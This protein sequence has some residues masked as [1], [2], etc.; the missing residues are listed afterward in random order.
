M[1]V[2]L[3]ALAVAFAVSAACAFVP[4]RDAGACSCLGPRPALLTPDRVDDAPLNTRVR[5]ELPTGT[6]SSV[7]LREHGGP[8]VP[9]TRRGSPSGMLTMVELSPVSPLL[10]SKQYEVALIDP[11]RHPAT[12][13][14][15][16]FRTGTAIDATHPRLDAMGAPAVYRNP[17][18]MGA[19]CQVGGPWI[20]IDGIVAVDPERP[21]AQLLVAVW[22][23]DGFGRF[24]TSRV[25]DAIYKPYEATITVGQ[26]SLCDPRSFPF[27]KGGQVALAFAAVDEA[28]NASAIRRIRVDLMRA[29]PTGAGATRP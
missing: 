1:A 28:G 16:T 17:Q 26:R 13:V 7:V 20:D 14:I 24:D 25:P 29:G 27:P 18:P 11:Q 15:G 21:A 8:D 19:A 10:P 3:R 22:V 2:G 6:T 9:V 4:L 5:L 12:T 23:G